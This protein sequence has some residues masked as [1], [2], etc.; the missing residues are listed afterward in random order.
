MLTQSDLEQI[1]KLI[2]KRVEEIVEKVVE[3]R[4]A[5]V[6]KDIDIIKKDIRKI[7]RRLASLELRVGR[8]ERRVVRKV[9]FV[10]DFADEE[11]SALKNRVERIEKHLRL[12]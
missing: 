10:A 4:L 9:N 6:I 11:V 12:N 5:P 3:R 2:Q 7:E 1:D 8:L